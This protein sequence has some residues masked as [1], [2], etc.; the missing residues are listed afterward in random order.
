MGSFEKCR[1]V[2]MLICM[3]F[4][5]VPT[6]AS[7]SSAEL[8]G[9]SDL[10]TPISTASNPD[11]LIYSPF[12][13]LAAAFPQDLEVSDYCL[14]LLR[15]FGQRYVAYVNC[16]VSSAR[17][18]KVCQN[19]YSDY[20]DLVNIYNNISSD[21]MGSVNVSCR[22]SLMES[23]R[24]MLLYKL[25]T[26]LG[27]LWK[28]SLCTQCLSR[29]LKSLSNDTL[30]YLSTLNRTLQCFEKYKQGNQS[31]L[32]KEC[33]AIYKELNEVYSTMEQN[34]KLCIDIEDAMNVTRQSWSKMYNCSYSREETVPVIAVSSFMIFLPVIF[35]L[36]SFLHS[37][38]KKR[39]LI[40]P[41]RAKSSQSFMNIQDKFS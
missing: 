33:K 26:N 24:L 32:C 14:D 4:G 12:L 21:Q 27:G 7:A 9:D 5:S 19:C 11:S 34:S 41:K 15:V 16:L 1:F 13:N 8:N 36:S 28:D 3:F 35:Y 31:E 40:H 25:F 6:R 37:E 23:D 29:D 2:L 18:V 38:Q 22:R 39:K 10:K 17:P 20:N 30:F